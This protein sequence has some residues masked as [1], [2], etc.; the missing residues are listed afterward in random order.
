MGQEILPQLMFS[1]PIYHI[2]SLSLMFN[3]LYV[4][5]ARHA[6]Q[7]PLPSLYFYLRHHVGSDPRH[8]FGDEQR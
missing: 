7:P 6:H 8:D 5:K 4:V 2:L 3:Y 1:L